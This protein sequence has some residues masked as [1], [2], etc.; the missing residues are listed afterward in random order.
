MKNVMYMM[1][2]IGFVALLATTTLTQT[3]PQLELPKVNE[4]RNISIAFTGKGVGRIMAADDRG[5]IRQYLEIWENETTE[6]NVITYVLVGGE[7][8]SFSATWG[9]GPINTAAFRCD[10]DKIPEFD[11]KIIWVA[12]V[13]NGKL[14]FQEIKDDDIKGLFGNILQARKDYNREVNAQSQRSRT[15]NTEQNILGLLKEKTRKKWL[16]L[17]WLQP[18]NSCVQHF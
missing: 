4:A 18:V 9:K 7:S 14:T 2:Q 6:P 8:T 1:I 16:E 10:S 13:N 5:K 3:S 17:G 12:T 11:K 15:N